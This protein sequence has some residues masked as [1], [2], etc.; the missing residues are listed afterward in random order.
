MKTQLLFVTV[1][2]YVCGLRENERF[3]R[4]TNASL[5]TIVP[6]I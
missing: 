3:G 2:L 5:H 1:I 6:L 4:L